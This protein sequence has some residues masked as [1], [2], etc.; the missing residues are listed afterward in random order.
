MKVSFK[1]LL[2]AL[3]VMLALPFAILLLLVAWIELEDRRQV[4]RYKPGGQEA[5][6]ESSAEDA[7][8]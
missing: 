4:P 6:N 7:A 5:G 1:T 8:E 2:K 3:L